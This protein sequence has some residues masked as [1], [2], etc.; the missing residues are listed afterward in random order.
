[1]RVT[2]FGAAGNAGSRIVSE[3]LGRGHEVTAV[4]RDAARFAQLPA[5]VAPRVGDA[6][7]AAQVRALAAG[8][9]VV[10][11]ATRPPQGREDELAAAARG[12]L[13]GLTGT[14]V[15]LLVV[16]GAGSLVVPGSGGRLLVDDPVYVPPAWRHVALGSQRQLEVFRAA[17][18]VTGTD[19][20]GT[21]VSA[22]DV[23]WAYVSPPAILEPGE[24]T[25]RYRTGHDEVLTGPDGLSRISMEDLA[26]A[27]LDEVERP[28][29]HRTRFTVVAD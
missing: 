19:S 18:D 17:T 26:I 29:H 6:S 25:G 10:I 20:S 2:V 23:D 3:A 28:R 5:R 13:A 16:G 7:R 9:D 24:R 14:G 4:V 15:R 1:M 8:Q 12:L 22:T 21:D 27:L 11:G